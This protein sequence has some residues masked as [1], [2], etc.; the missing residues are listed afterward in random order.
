MTSTDRSEALAPPTRLSYDEQSLS[1]TP[2][3]LTHSHHYL[4]RK[5]KKREKEKKKSRCSSLH[6]FLHRGTGNNVTRACHTLNPKP[7]R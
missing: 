5:T 4:V 6:A 7:T 2:D 1:G 3:T